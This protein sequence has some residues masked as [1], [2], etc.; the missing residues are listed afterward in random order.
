MAIKNITEHFTLDE[1]A[2]KGISA[3][4]GGCKGLPITPLLYFHMDRL[5]QLRADLD[6]PLV[7]NSGHRCLIHNEH[8]DGAPNS[9][10]LHIATDVRASASDDWVDIMD[11][12]HEL[13]L[14]I[15]F[16]GIGLYNTFI[17]LD[18]R[19]HLNRGVARWNNRT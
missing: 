11:R 18:S 13:A 10:H 3:S 14:D 7:V 1:L 19:D 6:R 15:G 12:V 4:C 16:G 17:H 8:C 5:E 2:C 9:M